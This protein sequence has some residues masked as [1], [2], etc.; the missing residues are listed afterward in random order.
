MTFPAL[1]NGR[2]PHWPHMCNHQWHGWPCLLGCEIV[3]NGGGFCV[4]FF[5]S[6]YLSFVCKEVTSAAK[7]IARWERYRTR[8]SKWWHFTWNQ[9]RTFNTC[10]HTAQWEQLKIQ[11]KCANRKTLIHLALITRQVFSW[12]CFSVLDTIF[13]HH[14]Q[15]QQK[16]LFHLLQPCRD[17]ADE[18]IG[19]FVCV[20]AY[21]TTHYA[22]FKGKKT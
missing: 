19:L 8:E 4:N 11:F 21:M 22:S 18:T 17:V 12:Y 3:E 7:S 16:C 20:L 5:S 15:I 2:M 10:E 9:L 13:G 14:A 6:F 1:S